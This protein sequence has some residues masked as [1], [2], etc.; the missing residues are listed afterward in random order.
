MP[1][2]SKVSKLPPAL[3][4]ELNRRLLLSGFG[5]TVNL[6]AW[7]TSAGYPIGKSSLNDYARSH[8]RQIEAEQMAVVNAAQDQALRHAALRAQVLAVAAVY[9]G[10]DGLFDE[11]ERLMAWVEAG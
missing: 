7:L 10:R 2:S 1:V 3:R 4:N 6:A 5:D 9:A 8:R 11:A